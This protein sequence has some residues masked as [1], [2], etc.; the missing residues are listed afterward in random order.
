M[1]IWNFK[2]QDIEAAVEVSKCNGSH[3]S[4]LYYPVLVRYGKTY[5]ELKREEIKCKK[6]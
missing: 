1:Y 3:C 4:K 5:K 6:K 2:K